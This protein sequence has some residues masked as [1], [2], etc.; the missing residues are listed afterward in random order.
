MLRRLAAAPVAFYL[1]S[2]SSAPVLFRQADVQVDPA[3][4]DEVIESKGD[5]LCI[6]AS[7]FR[8][9]CSGLLES[10]EDVVADESMSPADRYQ[11]LQVAV[12]FEVE[13]TLRV[14]D[15]GQFVN[16]SAKFADHI[17][18]LVSGTGLVPDELFA[19]ARHDSQ[20]FTHVTNTSGYAVMLA[21]RLGYSDDEELSEIAT[22][23]MLH[24]IGKRAIPKHILCKSGPL[25]PEERKQIQT[26][27][28]RG[29]EELAAR[30][31]VSHEQRMMV[32]QHHERIDGTG[33]PVRILGGEIHPWAK[34]LAVV[35]V[36]DALTGSRPYRRPMTVREAA[37]YVDSHAGTQFE[38]EMAKCWVAA[39]N[40]N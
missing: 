2:D 3:T 12:S 26:H 1:A 28:L 6:R 37:E 34:L 35:D 7:D 16:L 19:I 13:R 17:S 10:L 18:T 14:V 24:D 23:A 8:E 33:Y 25:N 32:Y 5:S 15:P 4:V 40:C 39:I 30:S 21:E 31:D 29:Y 20:T 38:K 9:A 27:P 11:M 22:G 36:F